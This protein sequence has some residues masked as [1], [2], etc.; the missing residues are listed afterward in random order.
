[1]QKS[2]S[3]FKG[4]LRFRCYKLSINIINLTDTLPSKRSFWIISDQLIRC[5]TSIGANL[6]EAKSASSRLEYKKFFE[7]SLK[8][9]NEAKYW[10][11]MIRDTSNTSS[12][13][14]IVKLLNEVEEISKMIASAVIKLKRRHTLQNF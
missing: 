3:K 5:A 10:L 14:D 9:S 2:K 13:T 8:S 12:R 7:I 4:D 6:V 1:M 11:C